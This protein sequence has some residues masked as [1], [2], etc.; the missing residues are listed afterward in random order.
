V[1]IIQY[2][3]KKGD[4]SKMHGSHADT[5]DL[6]QWPLSQISIS[7]YCRKLR[8]APPGKRQIAR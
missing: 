5:A 3:D 2:A 6:H 7:E 4:L 8:V 1:L